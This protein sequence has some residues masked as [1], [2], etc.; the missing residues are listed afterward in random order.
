MITSLIGS[1]LFKGSLTKGMHF[2]IMQKNANGFLLSEWINE[3]IDTKKT[4]AISSNRSISLHNF[5]SYFSDFAWNVDF[6][7]D[8]SLLYVN[9]L[10]SKK[11]NTIIFHGYKLDKK[12]FERCLGKQIIY[13]KN[14][15]QRVGRNPFNK[16]KKYNLWIYE[17]KSDLLPNCLVK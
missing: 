5:E 3:N 6:N 1:Q 12:P 13:K 14:V 8:K 10:K 4:I 16:F 7:N 11:I 9:F 15:G 17:F 2:E